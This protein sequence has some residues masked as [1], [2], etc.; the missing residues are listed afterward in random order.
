MLPAFPIHRALM[1]SRTLALALILSRTTPEPMALGPSSA[2][3]FL[4]AVLCFPAPPALSKFTWIR[5]PLP[6]E[7]VGALPDTA[8]TL[9]LATRIPHDHAC[10]VLYFRMK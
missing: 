2:L 1:P 4:A 5:L 8:P 3:T 7:H 9:I 10:P 6:A